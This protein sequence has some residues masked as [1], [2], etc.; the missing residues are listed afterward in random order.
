MTSPTPAAAAA[1]PD[2]I[3]DRFPIFE[4]LTYINSCSQGALSDSVRAAYEDY[5]TNLR[6]KGSDWDAW[7]GKQEEVRGLVGRLL[8]T[9]SENVALTASASVAL[10][11]IVSS[12]DFSGE[13]SVIVTT[14]LDFPTAAQVW[15][16]QE[17][18]GAEVRTVA[19]DASGVLDLDELD[20]AVDDRTAIVSVPHVCYRNGAHV[21]LAAAVEI[22]HRHGALVVV[23]A[24]QSVGARPIDVEALAPDF[25]VGGALKYLL[26]SPGTGFMYVNPATTADLVPTSTGWFAAR[27]IFAMSIDAYDPATSARRYEAGTPAV[28]SLYA[29]AAGIGLLL[30]VGVEATAEH[31][32]GLCARLRAGVADLGGTVVTPASAPGPL[33][34][35]RS[36]DVDALVASMAADEV[37]VSS[38]DG[39]L[40]VSP[41]F[42]N[43]GADIDHALAVL[44]DHKELLA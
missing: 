3:R 23:D 14:D 40:R 36:T 1:L 2:S 24:Y 22:A 34:A 41:H 17:R 33:I 21:D 20:R 4:N 38:R 18:R 30:E 42:Y 29:A 37:V 9:A 26:S 39:N 5:L 8:N 32:A 28:P 6:T 35:V 25:L 15:H 12:V 10:S 44:R 16:A 43:S 19:T 31:V 13:R 11:A 7:V 27:D